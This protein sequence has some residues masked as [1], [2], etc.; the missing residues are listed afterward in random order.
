MEVVA[1]GVEFGGE[2]KRFHGSGV[3]GMRVPF[4]YL[5]AA[6]AEEKLLGGND[7]AVLM[8]GIA[9]DEEV[10]DAGFVFE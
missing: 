8:E 2:G 7:E 1:C 6:V 10:G 9:G 4:A 5:D 3:E